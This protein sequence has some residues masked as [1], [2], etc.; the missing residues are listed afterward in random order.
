MRAVCVNAYCI[1][2]CILNVDAQM[3][4]FLVSRCIRA[5]MPSH[6]RYVSHMSLLMQMHIVVCLHVVALYT[7]Y[8]VAKDSRGH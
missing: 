2:E 4:S 8:V 7:I 3:P 6:S 5:Y 1:C